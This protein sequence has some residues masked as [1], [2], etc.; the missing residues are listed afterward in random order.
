[1]SWHVRQTMPAD[2]LNSQFLEFAHVW[3]GRL[4]NHLFVTKLKYPD[5]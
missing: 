3:L 1:M 2:A 5:E 4:R